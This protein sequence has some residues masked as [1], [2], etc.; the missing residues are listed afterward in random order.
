M[1]YLTVKKLDVFK[2]DGVAE[3]D[4]TVTKPNLYYALKNSQ[5]LEKKSA[6]RTNLAKCT[7]TFRELTRYSECKLR[8][9]SGIVQPGIHGFLLAV[10]TQEIA[11]PFQVKSNVITL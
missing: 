8:C 4:N 6:K 1:L 3:S 2:F 11:L 5:F 7:L 10:R 9:V